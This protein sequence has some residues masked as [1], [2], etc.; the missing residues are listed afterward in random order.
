MLILL[1][2]GTS[3]RT[4]KRANGLKNALQTANNVLYQLPP[5]FWPLQVGIYVISPPTFGPRRISR[6]C[7]ITL[8]SVKFALQQPP[9]ATTAAGKLCIKHVA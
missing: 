6:L 5:S 9:V 8:K 3:L 1:S 2:R 7:C 4:H